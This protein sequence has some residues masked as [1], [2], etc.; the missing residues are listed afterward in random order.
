MGIV[1]KKNVPSGRLALRSALAFVFAVSQGSFAGSAAT[2][3][4]SGTAPQELTIHRF[5]T[6]RNKDGISPSSSLI[7]DG[8]GALYGTT[9]RGGR[10]NGGTVFKLTPTGSGYTETILHS[11]RGADGRGPHG[12][13]LA[14]SG[15]TL[16]GTTSG[17][18]LSGKGVVFKLCPSRSG[19]SER[20][21]YNFEGGSDGDDPESAVISDASG[22]LYGTTAG[23]GSFGN[24]TV[25]AL[26]PSSNG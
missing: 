7:A 11:F 9:S 4:L 22:V 6:T 21:I 26:T 5:E 23:G 3:G 12:P 25:Y 15:G 8:S 24:G 18:G 2:S 16:Y 13:L 1:Q 17:G 20:V 14:G 19:F 10:Y